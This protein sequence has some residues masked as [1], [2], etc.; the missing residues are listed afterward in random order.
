MAVTDNPV[1]G[2]DTYI[3]L[4]D[5]TVPARRSM[6]RSTSTTSR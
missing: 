3:A 6:C 1:L 5:G 2:F 4:G